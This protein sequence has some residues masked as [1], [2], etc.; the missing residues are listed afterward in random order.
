M[1]SNRLPR[2]GRR[3]TSLTLSLVGFEPLSAS[4]AERENKYVLWRGVG[5]GTS[6]PSQK[7]FHRSDRSPC[8]AWVRSGGDFPGRLRVFKQKPKR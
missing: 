2:G 4:P 1:H 6:A 5:S 8:G 3:F 7:T